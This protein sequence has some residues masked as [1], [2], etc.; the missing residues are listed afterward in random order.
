M[1]GRDVFLDRCDAD[2][3]CVDLPAVRPI[4]I[5]ATWDAACGDYSVMADYLCPRGHTWSCGW[6][7]TQ[8]MLDAYD[9]ETAA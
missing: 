7:A 5:H 1:A 8:D 6:A 2:R 3:R 9:G 4:M